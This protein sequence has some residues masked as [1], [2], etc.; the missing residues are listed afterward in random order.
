M[1]G[2]GDGYSNAMSE[3]GVR[4]NVIYRMTGIPYPLPWRRSCRF[5]VFTLQLGFWIRYWSDHMDLCLL[6]IKI[7]KT[8]FWST[9]TT[10]F[11]VRIKSYEIFFHFTLVFASGYSRSGSDKWQKKAV[12]FVHQ[13]LK[14]PRVRHVRSSS[15]TTQP[16]LCDRIRRENYW[17]STEVLLRLL[18]LKVV[19]KF[20][21]C[22]YSQI[23]MKK[24]LLFCTPVVCV[25][26]CV[27][28]WDS[29]S[30]LLGIFINKHA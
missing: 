28:M 18:L 12:C 26:V 19:G 4:Y 14:N 10:E 25:C 29:H 6:S 1:L 5:Y 11:E 22:F 24:H 21:K 13:Q 23:T 8:S 15:D 27:L 3:D 2:G 16:P 20:W 7:R 30:K 17:I 9:W